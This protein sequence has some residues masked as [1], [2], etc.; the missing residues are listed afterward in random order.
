MNSVDKIIKKKVTLDEISKMYNI[1]EYSELCNLIKNMIN[2]NKI[3]PIKSSGGNGK[4]PTLCNRYF[5][6]KKV[7][8]N[9]KL[10]DEINF[11]FNINMDMSYYRTHIEKYKE[12]RKYLFQLN[13]FLKSNMKLLNTTVSMNERSFQIWGREKF[14]QKEI[15]K[16]ILKNINM[17]L[18]F[19]NYYN[20]SEPLAYYS[21]TKEIPQNILVL[22]NKDTYYT[23]RK[24]LLMN[25]DNIFGINVD[26]VIYGSGKKIIKAFEDYEISVEG[27]LCNENNVLYYFGDLDYEGI[28]I[29]ESLYKKFRDKYDIRPFI[30][31]YEKMIDKSKEYELPK[32]KEGQNKNIGTEFLDE[33]T[34]EYQSRIEYILNNDLYIPQ[35][36]INICDLMEE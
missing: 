1:E 25:E 18:E 34:E 6:V 23:M 33:F 12:H 36:I 30:K 4:N 5:I 26:T 11:K 31:G 16:T 10:I 3:I 20:T 32:T 24:F 17:S 21:R 9:S 22:E 19:L 28:I 27:Y 2:A 35:E 29:Y 13:E 8:D 15:G 14:I 7:E